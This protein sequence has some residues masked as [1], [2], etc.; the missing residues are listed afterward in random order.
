MLGLNPTKE[1][2][3]ITLLKTGQCT[4][5]D[6]SRQIGM[7]KNKVY[8]VLNDLVDDGLVVVMPKVHRQKMYLLNKTELS[9]LAAKQKDNLKALL[10]TLNEISERISLYPDYPMPR[11]IDEMWV[12][13]RHDSIKQTRELFKEAKKSILIST[14]VFDWFQ[15]VRDLI[16]SK[17]HNDKIHVT[18]LMTNPRS[19]TSIDQKLQARITERIADLEKLNVD[20]TLTNVRLPFRGSIVDEHISLIM[21]FS[22]PGTED[23][24][25]FT[26]YCLCRNSAIVRIFVDYFSVLQKKKKDYY[27]DL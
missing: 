11:P 15:D 21:L 23:Y 1:K 27:G 24:S 17:T 18:V 3:L 20:L 16:V 13:P 12:C 5:N 4:A 9:S 10:N 26:G 7:S 8:T 22:Y 2:I 19:I 25:T 6:V 14:H